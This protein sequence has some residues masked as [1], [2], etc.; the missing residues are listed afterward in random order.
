MFYTTALIAGIVGSLHCVGMCG[1]IALALPGKG[2]GW[3]NIL[4]GRLLYNAGRVMTYSLL[5]FLLGTFGRGIQVAGW[6]QGLSIGLGLLLLV[7][8]LAQ[9]QLESRVVKLKPIDTA[10]IWLRRQL[11]RLMK[12]GQPHSL[13]Q[14]GILNGFLPC[15]FVYL[16]LA[17][18]LSTGGMWESAAYMALFGLGTFPAMLVISMAGGMISP[19]FGQKIKPILTGF[20]V[21]FALLLILRGMNLGI[22]FVSPQIV[23]QGEVSCE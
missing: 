6:Q 9:L 7:L 11:G 2:R 16:A 15:G 12:Q 14:I 5:G 3:A 22:P 18:A 10:L 1:P 4:P 17:G 23:A 21:V 8:A 13:F 20:T 19:S